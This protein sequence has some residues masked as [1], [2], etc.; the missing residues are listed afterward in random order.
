MPLPALWPTPRCASRRTPA[1]AERVSRAAMCQRWRNGK[2]L[3]SQWGDDGFVGKADELGPATRSAPAES[4]L[5][6]S[7]VLGYPSQGKLLS[8]AAFDWPGCGP[9]RGVEAVAQLK[10]GDAVRHYS[11]CR[12]VIKRCNASR[13]GP[14]RASARAPGCGRSQ[15][16]MTASLLARAKGRAYG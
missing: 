10:P 11:P 16:T 9:R 7:L 14:R 4:A 6:S 12:V 1:R 8:P 5:P 15:R 2:P 3:I 13:L